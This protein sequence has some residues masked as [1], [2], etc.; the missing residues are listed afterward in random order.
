[1]ELV[2]SCALGQG[3]AVV[4]SGTGTGKT[5]CA[6]TGALGATMAS[7]RKLLYLT[8]TKSQQRQVMLELRQISRIQGL[9]GLSM[10]GRGSSC[11]LAEQ[12][13][14]IKNGSA[15][16]LSGFCARQKHLALKGDQGCP[17]Y[18]H[19]LCLDLEEM[20]SFC[21]QELPTAEE[22][23]EHCLQRKA[24]P[25]ETI[26]LL[27]PLADVV[28]APYNYLFLPFIRNRFLEWM[29]CDIEDLTV[30]VDE[31][32]NLPEYLRSVSSMGFSRHSLEMLAKESDE[33]QDPEVL[34]GVS[35][36]DLYGIMK[37]LLEE[38]V[39]EYLGGEDGLLPPGFVNEGLLLNLRCSSSTL[40][41]M[42]Q[43]LI[44]H[45]ILARD[46]RREQG[47][48]PRSYML[49]LGHFLQF[50]TSLEDR[51]Y[52]RLIT[53]GENPSF[54]TYCLDPSLAAGPLRECHSS[55]HMSGTLDPITEYRDSLG[56]PRNTVLRD[57]KS[58]FP[59]GNLL[60]LYADDVSTK[61]EEMSKD[62]GII[63]R[64]EDYVVG[65]CNATERN[66]AVF[67]PSYGLMDRF[68]S[69]G[70]LSRVS[71]NVHVETRG[72]PQ[73]E[74]MET[75]E[76]FRCSRGDVLFS[77]MGGRVSEGLDF[78]DED[79]EVAV[80]VGIPYPRPSARQ[81]ALMAYY[82]LKFN[83][84]WEYT[85]KAP[86]VRKMRQAI[87]RLIRSETDRGAAVILDRRATAFPQLDAK[88]SPEPISE[89]ARFFQEAKVN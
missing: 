16:E 48:L 63:L 12:D 18:A 64:M 2:R 9:L 17:F 62:R 79:M 77:V 78:P 83:K 21:R 67:F 71:C 58:P 59:S 85:V 7:G 65:L 69:D 53:G 49:S 61:Y 32:H 55:I 31:A 88:F 76:R 34:E 81:R 30:I 54:E 23:A 60:T 19:T 84:G 82:D 44:D 45:G 70:V 52:V 57:F 10:Q 13:P 66:T 38:A 42:N 72:M 11:P 15:E 27:L 26:K 28:V 39:D 24:C 47:R 35:V 51:F 86:T 6:L 75:V 14:E 5:I 29:N 33:F 43:V 73:V 41:N 20:A 56:L 50:W 80:L 8:R 46:R 74:L 36:L 68:I 87:G 37:D 22:F 40:K 3:H 89:V 4:E 1:V 25:Y